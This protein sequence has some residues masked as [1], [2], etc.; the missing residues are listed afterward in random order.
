MC[1]AGCVWGRN[2]VTTGVRSTNPTWGGGWGHVN[3][4]FKQNHSIG[5]INLRNPVIL[6]KYLRIWGHPPTP[7]G[8]SV[9]DSKFSQ[10]PVRAQNF[11]APAA[12]YITIFLFYER[13]GAVC[14]LE[15]SYFLTLIQ[16]PDI[17]GK[18]IQTFLHQLQSQDSLKNQIVFP[19]KDTF[20]IVM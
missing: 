1:L 19:V 12:G 5:L 18:N 8:G 10:I 4:V 15:F 16:A 9:R 7:R 13:F 3:K 11:S 17:I 14:D 20:R 6:L 2:P